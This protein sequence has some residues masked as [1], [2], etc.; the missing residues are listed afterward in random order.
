MPGPPNM[1]HSQRQCLLVLLLPKQ[2]MSNCEVSHNVWPPVV[3][4]GQR[5]HEL[6]TRIQQ[7]AL[8]SAHYT[9]ACMI[10]RAALHC[11]YRCCT[12]RRGL[13]MVMRMSSSESIKLA[14]WGQPCMMHVPMH[15]A[16]IAYLLCWNFI[17]QELH[18]PWRDAACQCPVTQVAHSDQGASLP[19]D[20][21]LPA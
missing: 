3:W 8:Q 5:A 6:C 7:I 9:I 11:R 2:Q 4:Q 14:P 10:K 15:V 21:C 20:G 12:G 16:C 17:S 19:A 18:T 13:R 1:H